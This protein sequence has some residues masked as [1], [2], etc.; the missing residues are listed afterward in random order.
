[1]SVLTICPTNGLGAGDLVL[2]NGINADVLQKIVDPLETLIY[3]A[4]FT[5]ARL[6]DDQ[7]DPQDDCQYLGG[8]WGDY[9]INDNGVKGSLL[10]TLRQEPN[11][12]ATWQKARDYAYQALQPLI[13]HYITSVKVETGYASPRAMSLLITGVSANGDSY[14]TNQELL[15]NA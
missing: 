1:M 7:I 9:L 13:P 8:Y 4:L 5:D 12:L 11:I 10:Y 3:T 14:Q 15:L 6:P 2:D